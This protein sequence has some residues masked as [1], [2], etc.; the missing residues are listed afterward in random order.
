MNILAR[1]P[2][3]LI[4]LFLNAY[5]TI[6]ER[7]CERL[8][9]GLSQVG[10][11][12]GVSNLR[13]ELFGIDLCVVAFANHVDVTMCIHVRKCPTIGRFSTNCFDQ[14]ALSQGSN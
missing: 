10:T 9:H 3:L 2:N 8:C 1:A 13:L 6:C 14:M 5:A 12:Q 11:C 7:P 4:T